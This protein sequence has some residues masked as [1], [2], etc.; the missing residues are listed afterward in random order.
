MISP[1]FK[2]FVSIFVLFNMT[3]S[4]MNEN[5]ARIEKSSFRIESIENSA[6]VWESIHYPERKAWS[7]AAIQFAT[8]K[9]DVLDL[10]SDIS[11]F[12]QTYRT[13]NR[14]DKIS[15][16]ANFFAA[17][18]YPESNWQP[19]IY[20][21][22]AGTSTNRDTWS[23]GL[24]QVSVIDQTNY[25]FNY[26]FTFEDLQL[27]EMN[28][29]LGIAIMAKQIKNK[30]KILIPKGESGLYWGTLNPGGRYD[31]SESIKIMTNKLGLCQ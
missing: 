21:V 16:W 28:L 10:A 27:A 15:V 24:L 22:D 19:K 14:N 18:S 1:I 6:L 3:V 9:L 7:N 23:V 20:S 5:H 8:E 26:N 17:L 30:G 31:K 29:Q 25:H 12:C 11:D 4:C 13:L 2:T